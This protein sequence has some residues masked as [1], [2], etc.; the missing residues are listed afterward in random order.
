MS[1]EIRKFN[2]ITSGFSELL[3]EPGLTGEMQQGIS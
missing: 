2:E 3:K 1:H